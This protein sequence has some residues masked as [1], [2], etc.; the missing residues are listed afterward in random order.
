MRLRKS[1]GGAELVQ[2][3][4]LL[5]ASSQRKNFKILYLHTVGLHL[6]F[7]SVIFIFRFV[8]TEFFRITD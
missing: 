6:R 8:R 1:A 7:E 3:D 2:A 4:S 5:Q